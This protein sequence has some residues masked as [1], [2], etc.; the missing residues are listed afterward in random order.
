MSITVTM[1]YVL[2]VLA[3]KRFP[4]EDEKATQAAIETVLRAAVLGG[5]RL[6]DVAR[7]VAVT[8]G[9]IDFIVSD[10][11]IEVK[12]KGTAASIQRQLRGYAE[13]PRIAGI[14]LVT[15]RIVALPDAI[16]G[17]PIAVLNM[18]RAWL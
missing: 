9:I 8:G 10:C 14:I 12:I 2:Q 11:G 16:N 17:K 6:P 13:D 4:L 15:S 1:H 5:A 3:N 7:E 18:G